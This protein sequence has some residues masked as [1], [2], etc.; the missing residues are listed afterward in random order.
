MGYPVLQALSQY[1]LLED[2]IGTGKLASQLPVVSK[3][4]CFEAN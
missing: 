1:V 2:Q 4:S 3:K